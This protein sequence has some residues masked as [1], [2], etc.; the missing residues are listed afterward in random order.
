[1]KQV[2]QVMRVQ[3]NMIRFSNNQATRVELVL[4][5]VKFVNLTYNMYHQITEAVTDGRATQ[6]EI[7]TGTTN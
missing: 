7:T 5:V 4:K 6:S 1:M 2:G 3:Q